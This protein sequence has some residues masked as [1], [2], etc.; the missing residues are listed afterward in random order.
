[1][2]R[3]LIAKKLVEL[4]GG[5]SREEVALAIGITVRALESYESG[6]RM[7]R[8]GV[9]TLIAKYYGERVDLLFFSE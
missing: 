6:S 4:R 8:D 9:K 2:D 7:P 3:S 1:M 5:K